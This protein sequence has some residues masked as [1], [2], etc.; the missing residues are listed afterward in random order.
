MHKKRK[1]EYK[2]ILQSQNEE[3]AKL[4]AQISQKIAGKSKSKNKFRNLDF[5]LS[6]L[7]DECKNIRVKFKSN[8]EYLGGFKNRV[9]NFENSAFEF[10]KEHFNL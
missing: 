7:R 8:L 2:K 1:I 5:E 10:L 9:K 4:K 3:I 6:K